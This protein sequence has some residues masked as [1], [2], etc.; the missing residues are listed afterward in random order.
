M[1]SDVFSSEAWQ[2]EVAAVEAGGWGGRCVWQQVCELD[3]GRRE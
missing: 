1:I 2:L 3:S